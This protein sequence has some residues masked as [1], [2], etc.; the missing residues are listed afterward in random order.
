MNLS[1]ASTYSCHIASFELD[2]NSCG[3]PTT[4]LQTMAK[5]TAEVRTAPPTYTPFEVSNKETI[6]VACE[7]LARRIVHKAPLDRLTTIMST[8][9]KHVRP[10]GDSSDMA[11]ALEV[12]IDT[13]W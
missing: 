7:V 12:A 8:R 2:N 6:A 10:D 11:S 3:M 13:H 9:F 4:I 1:V 5:I